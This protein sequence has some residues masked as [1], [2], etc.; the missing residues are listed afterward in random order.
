MGE[1]AAVAAPRAAAIISNH[2]ACRLCG[3]ALPAPFLDFGPMPLANAFLASLEE[4]PQE[5][6]YPLGVAG[7]TGCGLVQLTHVVPAE[8]LYRNYI[9]VSSTSEGVRAHAAWLSGK[10]ARQYG[11]DTGDLIVEIDRK[12]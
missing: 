8:Q 3:S 10:L 5:A 2:R 6:R 12:S 9:Y 1:S 4:A 7:C 11:W